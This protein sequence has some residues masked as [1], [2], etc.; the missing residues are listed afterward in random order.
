LDLYSEICFGAS[1]NCA[2]AIGKQFSYDL[3]MIGISQKNIPCVF[4]ASYAKLMHNLY[5]N[6]FPNESIRMPKLVR[7]TSN[8]NRAIKVECIDPG[9]GDDDTLHTPF[10]IDDHQPNEEWQRS[11]WRRKLLKVLDGETVLVTIMVLVFIGLASLV[12]EE[13]IADYKNR[14]EAKCLEISVLTLF[15]LETCLR[16][17]AMGLTSAAAKA[18]GYE[19]TEHKGYAND[20]M[21]RM[22]LAI[23]ILDLCG[24]LLSKMD[25]A[26]GGQSSSQMQMFRTLRVLR[27]ARLFRLR[28]VLL[29]ARKQIHAARTRKRAEFTYK[30]TIVCMLT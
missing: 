27:F 21:C 5:I 28:R 10:G 3:L 2:N 18:H 22:D 4:R 26:E 13:F 6:I 29:Q 19:A 16:A 9:V 1:S 7:P 25:S 30:V 11:Q 24:I 17:A 12:S 14:P 15:I 20:N 8:V 23:V